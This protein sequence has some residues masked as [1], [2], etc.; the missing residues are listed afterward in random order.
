VYLVRQRLDTG[1]AGILE[2]PS[3]LS[4]AGVA[5]IFYLLLD[6]AANIALIL[7]S[8]LGLLG[9]A[10]LPVTLVLDLIGQREST[11]RPSEGARD[12]YAQIGAGV[13]E[14]RAAAERPDNPGIQKK[15][16]DR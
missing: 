12:F 9:L 3:L 11:A 13:R 16:R 8:Y 6:Y 5:I 14:R 4:L 10:A 7:T 2:I 15:D 1:L